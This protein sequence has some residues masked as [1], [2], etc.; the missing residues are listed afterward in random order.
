MRKLLIIP[1]VHSAADLGRLEHRLDQIRHASMPREQVEA[2]RLQVTRFWDELRS[3][4]SEWNLDFK[5]LKVYQDALPVIPSTQPELATKIIK[6]LASVGSANHQLLEWLLDQGANVVGTESPQLLVAEYELVRKSIGLSANESLGHDEAEP[7][8]N[9]IA[10]ALEDLLHRRDK[11]IAKRIDETLREEETG[12]IFLG[13]LHQL[14][15]WLSE[16][17]DPQYPIGRPRPSTVHETV[18][19]PATQTTA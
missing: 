10:S 11:F 17:I 18:S 1:I 16:D 12:I 2:S 8:E 14:D 9:S 19:D 3:A 5:T 13:M 6:E 7:D 4:I 15:K